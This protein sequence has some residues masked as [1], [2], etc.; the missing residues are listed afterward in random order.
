MLY[1]KQWNWDNAAEGMRV[2]V[3]DLQKDEATNGVVKE[4]K[5]CNKGR[6]VDGKPIRSTH[7]DSVTILCDD[8]FEILAEKDTHQITLR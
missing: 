5:R 8:G 7:V 2:M 1:K 3:K 6:M 4:I